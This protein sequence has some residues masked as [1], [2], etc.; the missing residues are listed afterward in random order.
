[1]EI[2]PNITKCGQPSEARKHDM[3][4]LFSQDLF[5]L[6]F[7]LQMS[8]AGKVQILQAIKSLYIHYFTSF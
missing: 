6:F 2:K 3:Q 4:N 5:V 7:P 8:W 1:M